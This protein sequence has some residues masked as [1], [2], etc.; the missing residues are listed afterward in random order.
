MSDKLSELQKLAIDKIFD[1]NR[2]VIDFSLDEIY[3]CSS[4]IKSTLQ[5][6]KVI[7]I[8]MRHYDECEILRN[9]V[10]KELFIDYNF[11]NYLNEIYTLNEK[12]EGI[13]DI[14]IKKLKKYGYLREAG[15][16]KNSYN[17]FYGIVKPYIDR[18]TGHVHRVP[19]KGRRY[20][21]RYEDSSIKKA[22]K[23]NLFGLD[24]SDILKA[25]DKVETTNPL[26]IGSINNFY[27]DLLKVF[28]S[29][30]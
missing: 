2:K 13:K 3:E 11:G 12:I 27:D 21:I 7:P 29:C 8:I 30:L 18:R 24:T 1:K 16:L 10:D 22:L 20:K 23:I 14:L 9:K 5:V 19:K 25:I 15:I 6:L 26:V 4:E 17:T 28:K